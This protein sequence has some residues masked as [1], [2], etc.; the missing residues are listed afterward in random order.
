VPEDIRGLF[1]QP[2][3]SHHPLAGWVT[4]FYDFNLEQTRVE[5]VRAELRF[6][7]ALRPALPSGILDVPPLDGVGD[8]H[9]VETSLGDDPVIARGAF[10]MRVHATLTSPMQSGALERLLPR[11]PTR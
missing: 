9:G 10:R 11:A 4:S 5:P 8:G 6:T 2:I 3:L 7:E 1:E